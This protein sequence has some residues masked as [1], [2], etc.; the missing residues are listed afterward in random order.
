MSIKRLLIITGIHV[1]NIK[2]SYKHI[3][4]VYLQFV[5]YLSIY[6]MTMTLWHTC[7]KSTVVRYHR[8]CN[9]ATFLNTKSSRK[10]L[11]RIC[12]SF[13]ISRVY[14]FNTVIIYQYI[15]IHVLMPQQIVDFLKFINIQVIK[16]GITCVTYLTYLYF[17]W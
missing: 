8:P 13:Y 6:Y 14:T 16:V 9:S 10:L 5:R 2:L 12:R 4:G 3:F 1:H 11:A 7:S 17:E 15:E